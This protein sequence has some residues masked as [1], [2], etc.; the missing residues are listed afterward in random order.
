[1]HIIWCHSLITK[2]YL[3]EWQQCSE[4][5]ALDMHLPLPLTKNGKLHKEQNSGG[6]NKKPI[7]VLTQPC[8]HCTP[9]LNCFSDAITIKFT[10]C[11][12]SYSDHR[13]KSR[14]Y[15]ILLQF[16]AEVTTSI[17][18]CPLLNHM[19]CVVEK[20]QVSCQNREGLTVSI[21]KILQSLLG[22]VEL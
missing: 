15:F 6:R 9:W 8:A 4:T 14:K 12:S 7:L 2:N 18:I 19:V 20:Q 22:C 21:R 3:P 16:N 10:D 17:I 13:I 11:K 5:L 1:M